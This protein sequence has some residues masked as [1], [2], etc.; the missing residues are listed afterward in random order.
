M[1][2]VVLGEMR[3][4][5][6]FCNGTERAERVSVRLGRRFRGKRTQTFGVIAIYLQGRFS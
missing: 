6:P 4:M 5:A 1:L 3:G 2:G